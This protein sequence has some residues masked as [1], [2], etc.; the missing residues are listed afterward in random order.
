MGKVKFLKL[1]VEEGID[2]SIAAKYFDDRELNQIY[3]KRKLKDNLVITAAPYNFQ[4][5]IFE[6]TS[7]KVLTMEFIGVFYV[8]IL[9]QEKR[10]L[11]H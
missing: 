2:K 1:A 3:K 11:I 6:L 5:D 4:I 7:I 9:S 8:L 10:L